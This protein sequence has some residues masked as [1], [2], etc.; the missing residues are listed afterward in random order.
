MRTSH[1]SQLDRVDGCLAIADNIDGTPSIEQDFSSD[2]LVYLIV[3]ASRMW[4]W[5]GASVDGA[6][7]KR[8]VEGTTWCARTSETGVEEGRLADGLV[9]HA[10]KPSAFI[11]SASNG[12]S[13][14]VRRMRGVWP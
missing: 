10:E 9:R 7:L 11:A 1:R 2:F 8:G 5:I 3:F 4:A 13:I 12:L 6:E 14:A